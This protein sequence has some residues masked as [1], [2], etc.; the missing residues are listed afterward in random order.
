[1]GGEQSGK[2]QLGKGIRTKNNLEKS[3]W[4]GIRNNFFFLGGGYMEVGGVGVKL[5]LTFES[6]VS[7]NVSKVRENGKRYFRLNSHA[8][9]IDW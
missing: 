8:E 4:R 2:I 5:R 7:R 3:T 6:E 9:D 1:M